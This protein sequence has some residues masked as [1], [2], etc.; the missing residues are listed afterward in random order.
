MGVNFMTSSQNFTFQS[1]F[2]FFNGCSQFFNGYSVGYKVSNYYQ[3]SPQYVNFQFSKPT[4]S[5]ENRFSLLVSKIFILE[6]PIVFERSILPQPTPDCRTACNA[7][8][9]ARLP[10]RFGVDLPLL[11]ELYLFLPTIR[12]LRLDHYLSSNASLAPGSEEI[13]GFSNLVGSSSLTDSELIHRSALSCV[14]EAFCIAFRLL[15]VQEDLGQVVC[16]RGG[17]SAGGDRQTD[18]T[19]AKYKVYIHD[20]MNHNPSN[21]G[22]LRIPF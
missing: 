20:Y 13:R 1:T 3:N 11:S 8:I 21:S 7:L 4:T 6:G 16:A 15:R 14:P 9:E 2:I 18:E 17:V 5:R 10:L 12:A 22:P 19:V